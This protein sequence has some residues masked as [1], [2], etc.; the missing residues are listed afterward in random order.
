M[1]LC[2]LF[3]MIRFAISLLLPPD[4]PKKEW[5]MADV[6]AALDEKAKHPPYTK[7]GW[8]TSVVDLCR[9]NDIDP[10]FAARTDMYV[11]AGG[12][13]TYIGSEE[14]NI[15]LHGQVMES[16]AKHGFAD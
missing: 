5:T 15:W 16:L 1:I 4:K 9:L 7:L 3:R 14:Q 13:G 10:S 8:R 2:R 12:A 11:K 6:E